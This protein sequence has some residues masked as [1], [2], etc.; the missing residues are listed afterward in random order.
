MNSFKNYSTADGTNYKSVKVGVKTLDDAVLNLSSYNKAGPRK[1]FGNKNYILDC[2]ARNDIAELR[3]ISNYYY[4]VNGIY[5]RVC[6]YTAF[7]YRYDW[8]VEPNVFDST[9]KTE[10]V[11]KDFSNTLTYLDNSNI[12]KVCGETALEVIK[13]G[14]YYGYLIDS[15]DKIII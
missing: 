4:N 1:E 6:N 13:N 2:L 10:K 11:L 9:A 3:A 5:K 7:L 14:C 12:K 15:K 8:Y